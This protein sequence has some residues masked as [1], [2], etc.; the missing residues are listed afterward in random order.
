[1]VFKSHKKTAN[2][3]TDSPGRTPS[4]FSLFR[5]E[6]FNLLFYYTLTSFIVISLVCVA[7][8]FVFARLEKQELVNRSLKYFAYM[9]TNLNRA[10]YEEFFFPSVREGELIDLEN[11][12]EQVKKLD[13]VIKKHTFGYNL[14]KLY[15]FDR[16]GQIIYST[17]PEHIGFVVERGKNPALDTAL[18][19]GHA[20]RL[21]QPGQLDDKGVKIE[22]TPLLESYYPLYGYKEGVDE[23]GEQV[24]VIEIYQ[25]MRDLRRQIVKAQKKAIITAA[26]ATGVLFGLLFLVVLR[27]SK[28]INTRTRE[29]QEART[30][31]EQ[32]V[33]E[34]TR[35]IEKAQRTL[36]QSEKMVSLGR[37]VA[38]IAHEINNP[39]ASIGGCAEAL[40]NRLKDLGGQNG[41]L[42]DFP[43]Y[44]KI[45]HEETYRCKNI[46]SRLLNFSREVEPALEPVEILGLISEVSSTVIRQIEAERRPIRLE[47][48]FPRNPLYVSGDP[49]QLRQVFLNLFINSID[50]L[51]GQGKITIQAL[52]QAQQVSILFKDTG[53]GIKRED[54]GRV[55]D[56]F[57]TTKPPGKGT[58]LGLSICY[59]IIQAHRGSIEAASDGPGR[60]ATFKISLP[61]LEVRGDARKVKSTLRG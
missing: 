20:S 9:S 33:A 2:P 40:L 41:K 34:R 1:M 44:L 24:G 56:P 53:C 7:T 38:G 16:N 8:G 42:R 43:E 28:I 14:Q 52:C 35:E 29:L 49:Q 48:L 11:K 55:F 32:K 61:L 10:I 5:P 47:F 19:G 22:E 45:I 6:G 31:R 25:D 17:I 12:K 26:S 4:R 15:I 59:G 57:F 50:A 54:L 39:L 23:H 37:L 58:G 36:L 13:S 18:N 21:Q 51:E 27:G 60:G 3:S 30:D 46:I